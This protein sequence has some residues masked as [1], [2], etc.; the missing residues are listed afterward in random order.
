MPLNLEL[1]IKVGSHSK[2]EKI[3]T[4]NNAEFKGTL[5]QKDIYYKVKHGLLK[6]RIENG[7]HTLIK[8]L[9]D[10]SGKRWSNYELLELV[11]KNPARYLEDILTV[12]TIVEKKRKLY[13]YD[14][15]RI[16]L[17]D[18][19]GLGKYLELETLLVDD[20]INATKRFEHVKKML[21]IE[22]VEQIRASYKNLLK[23]K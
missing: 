7:K 3:L 20:K 10:E 2:L 12:E 15:T 13:L 1:K 22:N 8:Y 11:G 4:E 19:K 17:D 14:N 16:H 23:T 21:V 5:I 18:V 9:R 6:L